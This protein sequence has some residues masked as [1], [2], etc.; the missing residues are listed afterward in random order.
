VG[1]IALDWGAALPSEN[2]LLLAWSRASGND[3]CPSQ[4]GVE[5]VELPSGW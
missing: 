4:S 3:E 1:T 5:I 2:L